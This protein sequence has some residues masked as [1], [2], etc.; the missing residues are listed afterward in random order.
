MFC[1]EEKL[2]RI[3]DD[4]KTEQQQWDHKARFGLFSYNASHGF[5]TN[6]LQRCSSAHSS[7]R[8]PAPKKNFAAGAYN[9]DKFSVRAF[10]N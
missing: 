4:L 10:P 8:N 1:T 9:R 6:G 5:G 3:V 2:N 7:R